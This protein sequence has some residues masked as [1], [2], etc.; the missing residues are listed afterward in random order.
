[1]IFFI[2]LFSYNIIKFFVDMEFQKRDYS[3]FKTY[4]K[5]LLKDISP[6]KE[7]SKDVY[8]YIDILINEISNKLMDSINKDI[9]YS[10]DKL[11]TEDSVKNAVFNVL[12]EELKDHALSNGYKA[13]RNFKNNDDSNHAKRSN[14]IF[15]PSRVVKLLMRPHVEKGQKLSKNVTIFFTA[16]IEQIVIEIVSVTGDKTKN[17]NAVRMNMSDL[18]SALEEDRELSELFDL[19]SEKSYTCDSHDLYV[20]QENGL[21]LFDDAKHLV[22]SSNNKKA[23]MQLAKQNYQ[24]R[25]FVLKGILDGEDDRFGYTEEKVDEFFNQLSKQ[26]II[27]YIEE[28]KD[29][30]QI[31]VFPLSTITNLQ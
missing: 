6:S 7:G 27:D 30:L 12:P 5:R 21:D 15:A 28:L 24:L 1:M 10:K 9:N 26:E 4:T 8:E 31:K 17:R 25:F 19:K 22:I 2:F 13:L 3:S 29:D 23:L 18:E 14:L 16:I 11:I 20:Y